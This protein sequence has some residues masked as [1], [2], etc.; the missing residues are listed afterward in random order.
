VDRKT[1]V[2]RKPA[3][4]FLSVFFILST[5]GTWKG[6]ELIFENAFTGMTNDEIQNFFTLSQ[7]LIPGKIF[8]KKVLTNYI[9]SNII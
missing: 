6:E 8:L 7:K 3:G 5:T 2:D 9:E 4:F 1:Y